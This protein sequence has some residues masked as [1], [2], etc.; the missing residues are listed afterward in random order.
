MASACFERWTVFAHAICMTFLFLL[1]QITT[2]LM[3]FK[4]HKYITLYF[5]RSLGGL[6]D[7]ISSGNNREGC[8]L[9]FSNF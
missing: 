9:A 3:V 4:K 5:C 2:N 6:A 8:L 1:Q 7:W